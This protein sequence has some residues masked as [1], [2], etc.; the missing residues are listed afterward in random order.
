MEQRDY[1]MRQI[2]Q[3][4]QVL[5]QILAWLIGIR[6]KGGGSLGLEETAKTYK[7]QLDIDLDELI[8]I[9]EKDLITFFK[10]KNKYF[11]AHLE[12]VAD[13]LHETALNYFKYK[14]SEEGK[15]LSRKA[16]VIL[17]Y[18]QSSSKDYSIERMLK[19]KNY[20]NT[21]DLG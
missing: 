4:G 8:Q 11:E 17:E 1:L 13:I 12:I 21:I 3:L 19:I 6:Q 18:L 9:P 20:K 5:A 15:N 16:I 7:S 14:R 10:R 2:E